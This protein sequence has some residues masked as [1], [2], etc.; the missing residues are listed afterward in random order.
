MIDHRR[1]VNKVC[2]FGLEHVM[3]RLKPQ[4]STSRTR[5]DVW[6]RNATWNIGI[7][8]LRAEDCSR[9]SLKGFV[10]VRRCD[11]SYVSSLA[12]YPTWLRSLI[13]NRLATITASV[14]FPAIGASLS[15]AH[16]AASTTLASTVLAP[17]AGVTRR[18]ASALVSYCTTECRDECFRIFATCPQSSSARSTSPD[19]EALHLHDSLARYACSLES[20]CTSGSRS[21]ERLIRLSWVCTSYC[22]VIAELVGQDRG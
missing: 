16:V 5:S 8:L 15:L 11:P 18:F 6:P 19:L 13:H 3:A 14:V 20:D 22:H 21:L 2:G 7:R 12:V 9:T 17:G 1:Y 4:R 10:F